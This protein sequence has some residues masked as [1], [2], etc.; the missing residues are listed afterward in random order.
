MNKYIQDLLFVIRNCSVDNT[1]KMCWIKS[2]VECCIETPQESNITFDR[3]SRRMFNHYWNQTIHFDLRQGSNPIKPPEFL[4]YVRNKISGYEKTF[5]RKPE[6]FLRVENKVSIDT[7]KLTRILKDNVSWRFL[8]VEREEYPIY[9]LDLKKSLIEVPHPELIKEYSDVLLESINYR[10]SRIL[11]NFN[12]SPRIS[13]KVKSID[14]EKIKRGSLTKFKKYLDLMGK[15][16]FICGE[17]IK[18]ETPSIDHVIPWSY[19]Y[20][21]DLWNLVYTHKSCNSSKSNKLVDEKDIKKLESRNI[22]LMKL[23]DSNK[24][25][26]KHSDELRFSIEKGHPMMFWMNYK[27]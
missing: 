18:N 9:K 17:E 20:H 27:G 11:E 21:D 1:Y 2:I 16:C 7:K 15:N 25:N 8:K 6:M 3:V 4:T 19:M 14:Q 22:E 5:G 23:M 12:S 10:W 26:N 24:I 13:Q